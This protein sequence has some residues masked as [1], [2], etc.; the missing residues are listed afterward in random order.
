[1]R[2]RSNFWAVVLPVLMLWGCGYSTVSRQYAEKKIV[3]VPV[4]NT[5][6]ITQEER[7]Y[8][9]YNSFPVFVD[10]KLTNVLVNKFNNDGH[11][12]VTNEPDNALKLDVEV[13]D[14][15]KESLRYTDKEDVREQR[16]SLA[17]HL[18]LTDSQGKM[19]QEKDITG[20][21][22]YFL[23]GSQQK[24]EAA[25]QEDLIDD[26]GRKVLAAVIEDW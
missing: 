19:L 4:V 23:S 2:N 16:L 7:R 5:V 26:A 15:K 3:I 11:L 12:R 13:R 14:Y 10:K 6:N 24:S 17:V 1:M 9:D 18:K 25:A 20:E 8:S 21:T 22:T